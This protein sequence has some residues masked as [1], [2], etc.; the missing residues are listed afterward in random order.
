MKYKF[1]IFQEDC[2]PVINNGEIEQIAGPSYYTP[3]PSALCPEN[4]LTRLLKVVRLREGMEG[5]IPCFL[6]VFHYWSKLV[7]I[8]K[9]F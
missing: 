8:R 5:G 2:R 3:H 7:L 9:P 4:N 1:M 6:Y